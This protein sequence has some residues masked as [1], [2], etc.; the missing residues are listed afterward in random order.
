MCVIA[1][2]ETVRIT[3]DQVEKMFE[4]NP[5]GAGVAWRD[6]IKDDKGRTHK[7]VRWKKGLSLAEVQDICKDIP[8]PFV[9]HFRIPTVG[10][11]KKTLCHPFPIEKEVSLELEG[12]TRGFVLFHNGHWGRWKEFSLESAGKNGFKVPTGKWS[13]SR[14]MA[15]AAAHHG[16]GVLEFIDERAIAFSPA[17]IEVF[18]GGTTHSAW[19]LVNGGIFVSNTGWQ[20]RT[21]HNNHNNWQGVCMFG[22]CK[23]ARING[24]KYCA[25]HPDGKDDILAL[26]EKKRAWDIFLG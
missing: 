16:I 9:A 7:V 4:A 26:P 21:Q 1:V 18:G 5:A 20:F 11:S 25:K 24:T 6:E 17:E 23:L 22:H 19:T 3:P 13:D 10:G 8:L 2:A 15:W 14:A 12:T